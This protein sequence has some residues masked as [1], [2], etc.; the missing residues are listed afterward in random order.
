MNRHIIAAVAAVGLVGAVASAAPASAQIVFADFNPI[1]SNTGG[2]V[3]LQEDSTGHLKSVSSAT[4]TL[5]AFTIT[6]LSAFGSL[7]ST[8]DFSATE[9]GPATTTTINGQSYV[10]AQYNGS[11]NYYYTGPTVTHAG[12]TLSTNELLLGGSFTGASLLAA[13]SSTVGGFSGDQ[14]TGTVAY[15]TGLP[16]SVL[17]FSGTGEGFSVAL[18][19]INPVTAIQGSMIRHFSAVANGT[20]ESDLTNNG[21]GGGV[22]EPASWALMLLGF[23]GVGFS[24]RHRDKAAS[25]V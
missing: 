1:A 15:T 11:F 23:A 4:P 24:L 9:S 21:G 22:P 16:S 12:V 6:P 19:G 20:F 3:N 14:F 13:K 18:D 10:T 5:F 17:G 2:V 8:F 7:A 25:V